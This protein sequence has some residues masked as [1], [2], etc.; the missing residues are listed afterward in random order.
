MRYFVMAVVIVGIELCVFQAIYLLTRDYMLA[1]TIS[2][3]TGV[4]LNWIVGRMFVFGASH[5]HPARE[6]V[7]VFVASV[8]GLC[9]QLAV[10]YSCVQLLHLYPLIGKIASIGFSFFWNYWFRATVVYKQPK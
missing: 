9:I 6:F 4:L 2:F 5:H 8:V 10:V 3:I 7:M 1:T